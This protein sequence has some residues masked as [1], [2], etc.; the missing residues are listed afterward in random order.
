MECLILG[1]II[2]ASS[3][4]LF[5][6]NQNKYT[7]NKNFYDN[8]KSNLRVVERNDKNDFAE[9]TPIFISCRMYWNKEIL[10]NNLNLYINAPAI[11]RKVS[12]L[13]IRESKESEKKETNRK[14]A[15]WSENYQKGEDNPHFPFTSKYFY[16]EPIWIGP[17]EF[18]TN[19]MSKILKIDKKFILA[20]KQCDNIPIPW[21]TNTIVNPSENNFRNTHSFWDNKY[22][23]VADG[24]LAISSGIINRANIG[25]IKITYYSPSCEDITILGAKFGKTLTEIKSNDGQS[26]LFS[27]NK[28][29]TVGEVFEELEAKNS[30]RYLAWNIVAG[31]FMLSG[32][33]LGAIG[34]NTKRKS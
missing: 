14:V 32:I 19:F 27:R 16:N 5:K 9:N 33:T 15:I 25:D 8:I 30:N 11:Y 3:L 24:E 31:L 26:L 1:S 23:V 13:Q 2:S 12:M 18:N 7:K 28:R 10:D 21:I 22:K 6:C 29:L 20:N 4:Y 17:F 34:L